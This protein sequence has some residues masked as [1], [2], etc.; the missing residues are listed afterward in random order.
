[1]KIRLI[2]AGALI[3]IAPLACAPDPGSVPTQ[4]TPVITQPPPQ[5]PPPPPPG[6]RRIELGSEVR[7]QLTVSSAPAGCPATQHYSDYFMPCRHFE[8][9]AP[10]DGTLRVTL[11]WFPEPGAE[12]VAL[13]LAGGDH[14][15]TNYGENPQ[16]ETHRVLAGA[17]YG[18]SI[19]YWPTHYDHVFLGPDL[20][21]AFRLKATFQQ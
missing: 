3:G 14:P 15:R 5:P 17:T 8:V 19:V 7:E 12:A 21:G 9:V 20:I 1:M 18:I 6:A 11:D 10:A 13:I 2:V 16:V 4:P